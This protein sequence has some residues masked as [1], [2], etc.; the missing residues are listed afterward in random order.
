LTRRAAP[1]LSPPV[2]E[3]QPAIDVQPSVEPKV[4]PDEAAWIQRYRYPQRYP[5]PML[6]S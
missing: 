6:T 3:Q 5:A 1:A 4:E 2:I